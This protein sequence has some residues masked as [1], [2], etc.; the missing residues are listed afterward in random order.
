M[1]TNSQKASLHTNGFLVVDVLANIEVDSFR[2]KF[3]DWYGK[4]EP[5]TPSHGVMNKY[6]VAHQPFMWDIRTNP[7]VQQVFKDLYNTNDLVVSFDGVG[8]IPGSLKR[9]DSDW[10]HFDQKP[11]QPDFLVYQSFV[12]F[13]NNTDRV[14][15]CVPRSNQFFKTYFERK[16][17][18]GP[19]FHKIPS[20]AEF[21]Q[22]IGQNLVVKDIPVDKGQMVI[23]DSR[24]LHQNVYGPEGEHRLVMY[25]SYRPRSGMSAAEE[26]KRIKYFE[27]KR[28]TTHWAYPV[29]VIGLQPQVYGDRSKLIN[30]STLPPIVYNHSL[31]QKIKR[32][33]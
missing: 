13:S 16:P 4:V 7:K 31:Q 3:R 30:Y 28:A 6:Q 10:L 32:V 24:L 23:W 26:R 1:L 17:A 20:L 14:F 21:N 11:T 33:L 15:R 18:K 22:V 9:R 29:T 12:S 27:D 2:K 8:Y 5:E 25:V 19:A